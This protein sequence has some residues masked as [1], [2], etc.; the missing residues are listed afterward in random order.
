HTPLTPK[1]KGLIKTVFFANANPSLQISNVARGGI[2]DEK[3]IIRALGDG[4]LSRA[5]FDVF[6]N[7]P[8]TDSPLVAHGKIIVTPPLGAS[9]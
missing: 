2:I 7:W 1:T 5:A 9:T 4:Q 3:V 8:A 6:E